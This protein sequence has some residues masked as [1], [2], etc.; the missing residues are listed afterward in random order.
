MTATSMFTSTVIVTLLVA[1]PLSTLAV[2]FLGENSPYWIAAALFLW[3]L[4]AYGRASN[5]Q[6][7]AAYYSGGRK[8]V[9]FVLDKI[10]QREAA[11]QSR[12]A[13]GACFWRRGDRGQ[14][15]E[16]S[17]AEFVGG[18]ERSAAATT[19]NGATIA[20]TERIGDLLSTTR[21]V[22]Q[23]RGRV[24]RRAGHEQEL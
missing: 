7:S 21:A 18:F 6:D 2:R 23:I 19:D 16:L 9:T 13:V 4:F 24:R 5:F 17:Y 15:H 14:A 1:V 11:Y 3:P 10:E 22:K 8:A 20:A 12:F